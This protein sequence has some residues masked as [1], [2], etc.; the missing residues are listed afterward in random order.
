MNTPSPPPAP[1]PVKTAQAQTDSN[2]ATAIT[3]YGLNATNQVTPY[4]SL[5]YSQN[6]TWSD[7]TPRFTATQSLSP[8]QQKLF[9]LYTQNQTNLGQIGLQ[10][11][12]K[13]GGILNTPFDL[14]SAVG[15]QQADIQRKL[16]DPVWD[17]RQKAFD[18][19]M[20][21]QGIVPGSEAYTNAARDFGM[22]RDNAYNSALLATRGQAT[23]E[24]LAQRNQ[25]LNEVSAL[26]S[27]SQVSQPNFVGTPQTNVAPTDVLGAYNMNYQGQL[28]N[29]NAQ[30]QNQNALYGALGSIGGAATSMALG[31]WGGFG[32]K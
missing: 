31:G 4:G 3:Q 14:N 9:D 7:G 15:T 17:Q 2:K 28:N 21:D 26:M 32:K 27:G 5:T 19:Q 22:Q 25:P 11:T 13:V 1:D 8:E 18:A 20:R 16:L 12:Q 23:Q 30:L 6:G 24:A 10:Q 29:Y